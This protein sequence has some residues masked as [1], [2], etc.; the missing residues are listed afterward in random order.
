MAGW[1]RD[2]IRSALTSKGFELVDG[3]DHEVLTYKVDGLTR[4]IWT[5]LSRGTG[6]K[7]YRDT[8]LRDMKEQLKVTRQQL[9]RL[10]ECDMKQPEYTEHLRSRG[11]I[12]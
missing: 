4:A 6:Y 3:R 5:K 11:F 8:L 12:R 7:V 9:D 1:A 10:I 2:Q